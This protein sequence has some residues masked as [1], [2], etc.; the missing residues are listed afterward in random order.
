[1]PFD[2]SIRRPAAKVLTGFE[3]RRTWEGFDA[4]LTAK[5]AALLFL[6][7][8]APVAYVGLAGKC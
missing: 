6:F 7:T 4:S 2:C 3:N 8:F 5:K 1:M